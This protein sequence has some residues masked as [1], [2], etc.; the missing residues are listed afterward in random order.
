MPKVSRVERTEA[1]P[2]LSKAQQ[3]VA[4]A[5]SGIQAG[6]ADAAL[7]CA[8]HAAISAADAVTVALAGQRSADPNHLAA[9]DLLRSVGQGTEGI[10]SRAG[11]LVALLQKKNLVEY[12]ARVATM[13]EADDAV[14]RAERL[15]EWAAST[16]AAVLGR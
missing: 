6:R 10:E 12:Q 1:R 5:R 3:F 7:L 9:A 11:Q 15:V 14:K 4:E 8:I 16:I 13:Q 2:Y